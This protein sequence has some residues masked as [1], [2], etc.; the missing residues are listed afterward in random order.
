MNL[1]HCRF[2]LRFSTHSSLTFFHFEQGCAF[3]RSIGDDIAE[4]LG[5]IGEPEFMTCPIRDEHKMFILGSDGIFD[6][7][8]NEEVV[9]IVK[10]YEDVSEACRALV[11]LAYARWIDSEERTDDITVIVGSLS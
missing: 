9:D 3:S 7:I 4:S 6:F 8:S 11:G 2:F 10:G 5:V 1:F